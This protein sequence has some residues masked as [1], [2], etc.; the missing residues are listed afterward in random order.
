MVNL[1][2]LKVNGYDFLSNTNNHFEGGILVGQFWD[3][4][5]DV[6]KVYQF[7]TEYV[8]FNGYYSSYGGFEFTECFLVEPKPYTAVKFNKI[9]MEVFSVDKLFNDIEH[10]INNDHKENEIEDAIKNLP[11]VNSCEYIE[12]YDRDEYGAEAYRIYKIVSHETYFVRV[13]GT[14]SSYS[15]FEFESIKLVEPKQKIITVYE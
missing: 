12:G 11:Y 2:E 9:E 5:E 6:S 10:I 13:D 1:K 15:G 14:Y 4:Q 7:G 3:G 8:Q